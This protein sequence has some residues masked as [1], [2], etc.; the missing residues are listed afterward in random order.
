[1]KAPRVDDDVRG[2]ESNVRVGRFCGGAEVCKRDG[3]YCREEKCVQAEWQ[4]FHGSQ[5]IDWKN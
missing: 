2:F 3:N 5:E 1:V 4:G